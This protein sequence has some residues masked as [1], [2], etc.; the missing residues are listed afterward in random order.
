MKHALL[1]AL[2]VMLLGICF[3]PAVAAGE[4]DYHV[5]EGD[6]LKVT[7]YDHPDLTTTVRIAG[8]GSIIFPLI[9]ELSID[10]LSV[11]EVSEK[12][13]AALADGYIVNPQVSV[14][15]QEFRSRKVVIMGQV[16][17]PGLYEMSGPTT[18]LELISKAG[19]L[20]RD[21]GDRATVHRKVD[22]R[23]QII[24]IDLKRLLEEGDSSLDI[25]LVTGDNVFV[26]KAGMVYVTGE[27][28]NPDSYKIDDNTTVIMA[29][30]KA[31]G[32]TNLAS[33]GRVKVIRKVDGKEQIF[34]KVPMNMVVK[35]DDVVVVPESFF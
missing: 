17:K 19:G 9:G 5:G 6:V 12:L 16:D 20:S 24:R 26:P 35:P 32:F 21:A 13:S 22:G 29:V 11:S 4:A 30:T 2:A 28:D 25:P 23:E 10:G 3:I 27:V 8:G 1:S 31:G 7:V 14:F 34:E 18:L 33:K 15:V